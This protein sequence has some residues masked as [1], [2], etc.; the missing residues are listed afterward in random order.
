[1]LKDL[2]LLQLVGVLGHCV[3]YIGNDSGVTHLSAEIGVPTMA[4]FGPTD[5][6]VWAPS[7]AHV[8]YFRGS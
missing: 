6:M 8:Q 4:V 5:P 2:S 7:G 1:M 3:A